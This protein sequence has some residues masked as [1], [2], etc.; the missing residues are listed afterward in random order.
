M[1]L[2]DRVVEFPKGVFHE[3]DVIETDW[4]APVGVEL[5]EDQVS[6]VSATIVC[7][8]GELVKGV[9]KSEGDQQEKAGGVTKSESIL[10][11]VWVYS[12]FYVY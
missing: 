4:A 2:I 9:K 10:G 3:V 12:T 11:N 1:L 5:L 6:V 7:L 8:W